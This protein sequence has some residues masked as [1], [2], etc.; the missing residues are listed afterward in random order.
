MKLT[1]E[2]LNTYLNTG[3]TS[4]VMKY[5]QQNLHL[6]RNNQ[7]HHRLGSNWTPLTLKQRGC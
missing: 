7:K 5:W 3:D 4:I 6:N 2:D 1:I